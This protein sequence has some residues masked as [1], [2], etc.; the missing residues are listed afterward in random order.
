MRVA[1]HQCNFLPWSGFFHKMA[2]CDTFVILDDV[3][4]ERKGY[5]NRV[6]IRTNKGLEWLTVPIKHQPRETLIRDIELD[7][8]L[9]LSVDHNNKLI[10]NYGMAKNFEKVYKSIRN[11]YDINHKYLWELNMDFIVLFKEILRIP[12]D[13]IMSS[14]LDVKTKGSDRILDIC[15]LLNADIY[16]MG[17]NWATTYLKTDDFA[18]NDIDVVFLEPGLHKPYKQVYEPFISGASELDYIMNAVEI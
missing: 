5:T 18:N 6:Q 14:D 9:K 11:I 2:L 7:N 10:E 17:K 1:I 4:Y 3:Q 8:W 16:L 12:A 15:R 13:I